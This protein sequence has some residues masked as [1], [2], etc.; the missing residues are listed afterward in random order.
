[1]IAWK[2]TR[3]GV[4]VLIA[5]IV[6]LVHAPVAVAEAAETPS[7]ELH[8]EGEGIEQLVLRDQEGRQRTLDRPGPMVT[9]PVGKYSVFSIKLQGGHSCPFHQIPMELRAAVDSNAPGALKIGAPLR[10]TVRIARQGPMMV[11]HYELIGQGGERYAVE[12]GQDTPKPAF[13]VYRGDDKVA[14]GDF[15][16]G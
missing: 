9:L 15:E 5:W 12:R 3:C 13:A 2:E 7:G 10:Q 4:A 1:M 14:S 16:F 6:I 11:L 8:I